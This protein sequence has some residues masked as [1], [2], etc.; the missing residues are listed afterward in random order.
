MAKTNKTK[1]VHVGVDIGGTKLY[2]VVMRRGK[3]RGR[4]RRKTRGESGFEAVLHRVRRTVKEAC[5][6]AGVELTDV[7]AVGVGAPSPLL[8]DG[9]LV[10][11]PNL[12]WREV[13]LGRS[14][15]ELLGRPVYTIND[16]NAG[17]L[18]ELEFGAARGARAAV[19]LFMGT[20]L[21][22]G[23]VV[24]GRIVEG[25]NHLAAELGHMKVAAGGRPCGCGGRG[26]LEAYASK[27]GLGYRLN[28]EIACERRSSM[29]DELC[30]G[31]FRNVR[32]GLLA[33]AYRAGDPVAVEALNEAADYLGLGVAN[34]LTILGPEV[35]VL[36]GGV[37][38]A[39][40][41]ELLPRVR[42]AARENTFP[43]ACYAD[44][45]I[46]VAELGDDSVALGALAWA[47]RGGAGA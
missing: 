1:A 37:M 13:P 5:K 42:R 21:G 3:V 32:S 17:T 24:D 43:P 11:A 9:T 22:G 28:L 35:V 26:C 45:R 34:C 39:L 27:S 8:P 33:R 6:E 16:C 15:T 2:A 20:G 30:G 40:G 31:D 41:E 10:H 29:L 44:A 14:L 38:E 47:R 7:A 12:G 4:A 46:A 23:I 19:G 36:G 18:A 25:H